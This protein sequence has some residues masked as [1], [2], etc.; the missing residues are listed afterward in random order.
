MDNN[1][2]YVLKVARII[3]DTCIKHGYGGICLFASLLLRDICK[4]YDVQI[5]SGYIRVYGYYI[6]HVWC[7]Y[8][9]NRID[10]G[11]DVSNALIPEG[12]RITPSY[13]YD[14]PR[15]ETLHN[16]KDDEDAAE[17][18][19]AYAAYKKYNDGINVEEYFSEAPQMQKTIR[20]EVLKRLQMTN[21]IQSNESVSSDTSAVLRMIRMIE[22]QIA[23]ECADRL[24]LKDC[25]IFSSLLLYTICKDKGI[26]MSIITDGFRLYRDQMI[27]HMWCEYEGQIID[28]T[29]KIWDL[30]KITVD[31]DTGV[32]S[33]DYDAVEYV[34][35]CTKSLPRKS[36]IKRIRTAIVSAASDIDK[37]WKTIPNI[38]TKIRNRILSVIKT[39]D[40]LVDNHLSGPVHQKKATDPDSANIWAIIDAI[41]KDIVTE[42][43][44]RSIIQGTATFASILLYT[45]CRSLGINIEL[46]A[47]GCKLGPDGRALSHVWCEY[48]GRIIDVSKE[49]YEFSMDTIHML[50]GTFSGFHNQKITYVHSKNGSVYPHK[51]VDESMRQTAIKAAAD[52]DKYW[53]CCPDILLDIKQ[54]VM[55]AS[56]NH[57]AKLA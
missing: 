16:M 41:Q 11:T 44:S 28:I 27:P 22:Y 18:M 8:N 49:I 20:S 33:I 12:L 57:Y 30:K 32:S 52:I 23:S 38:M 43:V 40:D 36:K 46:V 47:D 3:R 14:L 31:D 2:G 6:W 48:E 35:D 9:G 37:Y 51:V 4:Q 50:S 34:R 26:D 56:K 17:Y 29:K 5:I 1:D 39:V 10:I 21:N 25:N 19:E 15:E 54:K 13:H 55:A 53:Q 24:M 42:C 7:E 45:A